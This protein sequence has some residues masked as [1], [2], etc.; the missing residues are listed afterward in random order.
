MRALH[1]AA[2]FDVP[3]LIRVVLH[4]SQPGG[5]SRAPVRGDGGQ[6]AEAVSTG[7][8]FRFSKPT[9]LRIKTLVIYLFPAVNIL[10]CQF[11]RCNHSSYI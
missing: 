10:S 8:T 5:K 2:Y 4:A 6:T 3:Q 1:Y 11:I 7:R 9:A